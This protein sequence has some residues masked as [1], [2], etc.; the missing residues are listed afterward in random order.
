MFL[1][2]ILVKNVEF[3]ITRFVIGAMSFT[4]LV[5]MTET[6]AVIL[7]SDIPLDLKD[8]LIVFLERTL[9]TL[10]IVILIANLVF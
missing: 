8:L 3:E 6:G 7:R 4:Q 1:P 10:P 2:S 9:I 5:Y